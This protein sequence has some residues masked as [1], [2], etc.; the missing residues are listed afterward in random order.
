VD[1]RLAELGEVDAETT[2]SEIADELESLHYRKQ[3]L[4]ST[5]NALSPVVEMN[6]QLVDESAEVPDAMTA[7]E[8]VSEL[9]PSSR[10]VTCWTCGSTVERA[11][12]AEQVGSVREIL[13]EKRTKREATTERVEALTEQRREL[14]SEHE[15][16]EQLQERR[17]ELRDELDRRSDTVDSLKEDL[18]D[19]ETEIERLQREQRVTE[20]DRLTE[21]YDEISDLEYERGRLESD[22]EEVES[23]VEEAEE[24]LAK[25]GELEARRHSVAADLQAKRDRID[26][27]ERDLVDTFNEMMQRV[28]EVLSYDAIERVWLERRKTDGARTGSRFA[29]HIVRQ[30]ADGTVYEDTVD[31]LSKSEREVVGLVVGLA[32]YLV[33]DVA[34]TVP[35]VVIDAV[36]MFDAERIQPLMDLFADHAEYVVA[37]VLPAERAQIDG[38]FELLPSTEFE[39]DA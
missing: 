33:H 34:E 20:D 32:G 30:T 6:Q 13:A 21:R 4:T 37:T 17:S 1:D 22:L 38:E 7:D 28:L 10:T 16:R 3:Q 18:R 8:V 5:I 14:E 2:L 25:R 15:R 23:E 31:T 24:A 11:Q 26:D 27:I 29:L 19:L 9:D 36:E 35:F 39:A 12:I